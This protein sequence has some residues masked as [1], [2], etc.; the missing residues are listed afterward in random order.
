MDDYSIYTLSL[1][2]LSARFLKP[3]K[4][5]VCFSCVDCIELNFRKLL[6][7]LSDIII[8]T[9]GKLTKPKRKSIMKKD[10]ENKVYCLYFLY[11]FCIIVLYQFV[12]LVLVCFRFLPSI[13][14][15]YLYTVYI[16]FYVLYTLYHVSI[17]NLWR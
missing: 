10:N 14:C 15:L 11:R 7:S 17:E 12:F 16:L 6:Y 5:F 4:I 13:F 1:T 9:L 2:L 8:M 3:A